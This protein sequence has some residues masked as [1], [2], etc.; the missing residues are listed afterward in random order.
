MCQGIEVDEKKKKR[1]K[2]ASFC[3]LYFDVIDSASKNC[4]HDAERTCV[5]ILRRSALPLL[6]DP[7]KS[8]RMQFFSQL[9]PRWRRFS[10]N[11]REFTSGSRYEFSSAFSLNVSYPSKVHPRTNSKR[12]M[13][14]HQHQPHQ[15]VCLLISKF[16]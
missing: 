11:L 4:T 8:F 15:H 10:A 3:S 1:E 14:P 2:S 9:C 7:C 6:P 5:G 13:P 16:P 12:C